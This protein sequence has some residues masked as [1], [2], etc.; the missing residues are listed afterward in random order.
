MKSRGEYHPGKS[1]GK[2][3]EGRKSE[4]KPKGKESGEGK[5]KEPSK[6]GEENTSSEFKTLETVTSD[7]NS[8]EVPEPAEDPI[9]ATDTSAKEEPA[10]E[11]E[12]IN[13]ETDPTGFKSQ[14]KANSKQEWFVG[15]MI[16]QRLQ[17]VNLCYCHPIVRAADLLSEQTVQPRHY[18]K[19]GI[20]RVETFVIHE[21]SSDADSIE[22]EAEAANAHECD[23]EDAGVDLGLQYDSFEQF[24]K[25]A[26]VRHR[27][28]ETRRPASAEKV[29]I[30][31]TWKPK[32][33]TRRVWKAAVSRSVLQLR[34]TDMQ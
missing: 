27:D 7:G 12:S 6:Q 30:P 8:A 13:D 15:W 24:N 11:A 18:E 17:L 20:D 32:P 23:F 9:A 5:V 3:T 31:R 16:G 22:N 21:Q 1:K 34:I 25:A 28:S 19:V 14:V 26:T 4:G 10:K 29:A 33:A 2:Q